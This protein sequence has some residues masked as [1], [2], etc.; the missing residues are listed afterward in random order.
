MKKVYTVGILTVQDL[1]DAS[2]Q[3]LGWTEAKQKYRLSV[4]Q[5][6]GVTYLSVHQSTVVILRNILS[7]KNFLL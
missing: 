3:L 1:I 2:G 4:Y 7:T 5:E 6:H